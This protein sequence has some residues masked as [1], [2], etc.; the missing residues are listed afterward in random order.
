MNI[1]FLWFLE[2][3]DVG[4]LILT[5]WFKTW[6]LRWEALC[7]TVVILFIVVSRVLYVLSDKQCWAFSTSFFLSESSWS[8]IDLLFSSSKMVSYCFIPFLLIKSIVP[9]SIKTLFSFLFSSY[10]VS[11]SSFISF[12]VSSPL[13]SQISL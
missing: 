6:L 3:C 4:P 8:T 5:R 7:L 12:S 9:S 13:L 10:F 2:M 11:F 1:W